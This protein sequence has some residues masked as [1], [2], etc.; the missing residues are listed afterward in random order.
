[1]STAWIFPGQGAE[2]PGM[3]LSDPNARAWLD[4]A[5]RVTGVDVPRAL[6]RGS[7]ALARTEVLQ[8]VLVAVGLASAE[9]LDDAPDLVAGHSLGELM[10]VCWAASLSRR[11]ALELAATRGRLMAEAAAAQPGGMLAYRGGFE[12]ELEDALARGRAHGLLGLAASNAEEETVVSGDEAALA[13]LQSELRGRFTRLRVAGAWH[14]ERMRSA[15]EPLRSA[16]RVSLEGCA[17]R[18][19]IVSA[20]RVAEVTLEE[21][22][23]ALAEAVV[24]PVRFLDTV[25]HL[26]ERG[27]ERAVL[28]EPGRTTR[29]LLR[30]ASS[31]PWATELR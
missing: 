7:R 2:T 14:S 8:P 15:V 30:R 19:P 4:E 23:D 13:W 1:M 26:E 11:E 28:L 5:S 27:V 22:P 17:L 16:L 6:E 9:A 20:C 10:A 25:R 3:G 21:I 24:R 29:S 12:G 18:A 31:R